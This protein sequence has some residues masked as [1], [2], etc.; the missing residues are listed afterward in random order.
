M[1]QVVEMLAPWPGHGP[2]RLSQDEIEPKTGKVGKVQRNVRYI[3]NPRI[4]SYLVLVFDKNKKLVV[5][6]VLLPNS[7]PQ[8]SNENKKEQEKI[9]NMMKQYRFEEV[10]RNENMIT[11]QGEIMHCI[12]VEIFDP[13][14][15][16]EP[17]STI[18]YFFTC[19]TK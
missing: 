12:T 19:P 16:E 6:H 18:E 15:D 3:Y 8:G 7:L 13:V 17:I 14:A 9:T 5:I 2:R 1:N 10:S 4:A 11:V